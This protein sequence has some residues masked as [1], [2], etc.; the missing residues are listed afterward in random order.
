M[1]DSLRLCLKLKDKSFVA[2]V[3]TYLAE[4]ALWEGELNEA[5]LWLARS[6]TYHADPLRIGIDQVQRIFVAARLAAAQERYAR[7]ATLFGLAAQLHSTI[8]NVITG[9]MPALADAALATV[10]AA[11]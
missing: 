9:P 3:C 6:L 7:A 2:R 5:E 8:H 11:L 1:D 4:I 10:Q